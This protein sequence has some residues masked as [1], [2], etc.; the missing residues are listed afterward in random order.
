VSPWRYLLVLLG[1]LLFL[2]AAM[3]RGWA[4]LLAWPG[5]NFV[6]LGLAYG[7]DRHRLFGKRADGQLPPWGRVAFAPLLAYAWLTWHLLRLIERE[8]AFCSVGPDLVL[9]RRLLAR[10]WPSGFRNVVDLT[11]EFAETKLLR[12]S[13]GYVCF[14]V[15]DGSAPAAR[16][17]LS[18]IERLKPGRTYVHCAQ[19]HGR[20]ALFA[21]ALLLY[22]QRARIP[23][24]ALAQLK[25]VRPG[26]RLNRAQQA[27][28]GEFMAELSRRSTERCRRNA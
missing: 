25:A 11:A 3:W 10:E 26:V 16:E 22:H 27:C 20:S 24:E 9:G 12:S 18:V 8:P 6:A 5:A 2:Q 4:W 23:E 13:P 19:G 17:L 15:L 28:L 7:L 21:V 14:P 1:L